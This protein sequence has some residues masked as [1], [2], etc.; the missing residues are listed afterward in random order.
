M[1]KFDYKKGVVVGLIV[2][3]LSFVLSMVAGFSQAPFFQDFE[4]DC[5]I[6][7]MQPFWLWTLEIFVLTLVYGVVL[8]LLFSLHYKMLPYKG[9]KKG[10]VFGIV[11]W[12]IASLFPEILNSMVFNLPKIS[13][14]VGVVAELF[15]NVVVWGIAALIYEKMR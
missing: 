13:V 3:I 14:V 1:L 11:I 6:N 10:A 4:C 2:G 7:A 5:M 15:I 8:G 9:F 12:V